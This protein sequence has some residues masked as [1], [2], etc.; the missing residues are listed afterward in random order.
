MSAKD[1][2]RLQSFIASA[3]ADPSLS[4]SAPPSSSDIPAR[5]TQDSTEVIVPPLSPRTAG[6]AL[7]GF[8]PY[9]DDLPRQER[10]KSYLSSQTYNTKTPDPILHP[11]TLEQVNKE[12]EDFAASARIFKPMSFAMSSRF[13]SG[14]ASLAVSDL[15]QAKPGLHMYDASKAAEV[16]VDGKDN[17]IVKGSEDSGKPL[18]P[19]EQAAKDGKYGTATRLVK[20]FYPTK[21]VCRRFG[22]Q[23]PHP[24]GEPKGID[25]GTSNGGLD[26]LPLPKNDAS[27]ESSFVHQGVPTSFGS[28]KNGN[29]AKDD[30]DQGNDDEDEVERAPRTLADVGMPGDSNQGRDT[31][32]YVKPDI[33]IFK[34]IFAEDDSDDEDGEA[35]EGGDERNDGDE[36]ED[37]PAQEL[38]AR[39]ARKR[40]EEVKRKREQ[41]REE[42]EKEKQQGPVDLATFKPVFVRKLAR[43]TEDGAGEKDKSGSEAQRSKKK[44]KKE[45][46]KLGGVLSFQTEDGEGEG[47][48]VEKKIK[49][50]PALLTSPSSVP[51][52]ASL[53]SVTRE[54]RED[55]EDE[56]RSEEARVGRVGKVGKVGKVEGRKGAEHFM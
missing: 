1:R 28:G 18:G 45:S 6:A 13:T 46:K 54:G 17:G 42:R 12:L 41:E 34:A 56:V 53:P 48:W 21:L 9:G 24:E 31:L 50:A 27:W 25:V 7:N 23:D 4:G 55:R 30:G 40:A 26:S 33:D 3:K 32:T 20:A 51:L 39:Q 15:K 47:E 38:I 16:V 49:A 29:D 5:P 8:I 43:S 19:R 37:V 22:V 52:P 11:G 36:D 14:S 35:G 44:R 2:D 10:Y